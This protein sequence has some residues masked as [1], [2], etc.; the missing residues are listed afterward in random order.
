MSLLYRDEIE[1]TPIIRDINYRSEVEDKK[2]RI[3]AH[4]ESYDK[5]TYD[6]TGA[7]IVPKN[8]IITPTKITILVGYYA[9][10]TKL[11]GKTVS[12]YVKQKIRK[13]SSIGAF[14]ESHL[15]ILI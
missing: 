12:G 15:E 13:V 11:H 1:I 2:I 9:R 10:I 8:L 5:V 3:K 14:G 6:S 4:V 7:P